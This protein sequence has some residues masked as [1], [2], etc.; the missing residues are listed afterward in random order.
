MNKIKVG[1]F[2]LLSS[3]LLTSCFDLEEKPY[4][5]LTASTYF[6][7]E[8]AVQS[9]IA[10]IYAR[11]QNDLSEFYWYMQELPADQ[12]TWRSWYGGSWGWD[13]AYKFVLS[14]HTWTPSSTVIRDTWSRG[15]Q[16]IGLCNNLLSD[17]STLTAAD[18]KMSQEKL[19]TYIAEVRTFR[20]YCYYNIYEIWGGA[21]PLCTTTSTSEIPGSVS[22]DFDE[23]CQILWD[24]MV[25]ELDETLD[26]LPKNSVNRCNQAMNRML[27]MRLLLNS[28][29][30]TGKP[31]F[32]ECAQLAQEILNGQYGVY[33]L[34]PRYQDIYAYDNDNCP[35]I[36]FAFASDATHND[37]CNMRNGPFMSYTFIDYF[38]TPQKYSGWNCCCLTPSF[39]NS[40][41]FY[42]NTDLTTGKYD[43]EK[44]VCFLDAPYNDKLGAV[45]QRFH[46]KDIRKQNCYGDDSGYF[47]GMFLDGLMR[48]NYGTGAILLADADRNKQNLIY[49]DQ[50]GTFSGSRGHL[51]ETVQSPRWGET[52]SGIRV[53]KY[54]YYTTKSGFD[55][56]DPDQVEFRLAEVIYTLAE[57]NMREGKVDAAQSL[58]NSVR[59]RCFSAEDWAVAQNELPRGFYAFDMDWMLSEWGLEFLD[60]GHRRRTDLRRFDKFTQGQWWF[61]G[62]AVDGEVSY[63]AKRDRKYEWYPLPETALTANPGL[64][65]NPDYL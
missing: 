33:S 30:F 7:D 58:V 35:E 41:D 59:K 39:D 51:V 48:A 49:V 37:A 11:E 19:D 2:A 53:A 40:Y 62:R 55:F 6:N 28:E 24:F 4:T 60:E 47:V 1:I 42:A 32:T 45:H 54:P 8:A 20:V 29:I 15:W 52:N 10:N 34:A 27:K 57:C 22:E 16:A 18:L 9:V 25:K 26:L 46:P 56:R 3:F 31:K 12:L 38:Q 64:I 65:Q 13:S 44:A 14:T 21:L 63:P 50:V 17:L 5:L 61:F 43:R 23:G 36:I